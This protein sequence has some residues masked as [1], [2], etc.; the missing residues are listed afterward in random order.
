MSL[1]ATGREDKGA[2][3]GKVFQLTD[4]DY[5]NDIVKGGSMRKRG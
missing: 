5:Q 1:S 2:D 3:S 4:D